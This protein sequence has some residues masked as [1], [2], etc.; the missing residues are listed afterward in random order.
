MS[1]SSRYYHS[2]ED[3]RELF[4]F[5]RSFPPPVS[6]STLGQNYD[7]T[8]FRR[9]L[10]PDSSCEVCNNAATEIQGLF[11]KAL[12]A[13]TPSVSPVAS[14]APVTASTLTQYD[15]HHGFLALRSTK[16]SFGADPEAKLVNPG[17]LLVLGPDE[18]D[19]AQEYIYPK[20]WEDHL[21]KTLAQLFWGLPTLHSESLSS[22]VHASGDYSIFF[23]SISNSFTD[24][25]S[26]GLAYVQSP[27]LAE[28]QP[29]PLPQ[30]LPQS[31]H[32]H[33]TQIETQAHLQ[34]PFPI[35]P[36]SPITRIRSVK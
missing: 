27:S 13:S 32:L 23:N 28:V 3:D 6:C 12:E 35:L 4:S 20:T 29:Q 10:C 31:Q 21:K 18:H 34:S 7:I 33:L 9:L 19:S 36:S 17:H 14:T 24:Q 25:E 8:R 16:T 15:L 11:L 26:P 1:T 30:T 22:A 5:L 2:E